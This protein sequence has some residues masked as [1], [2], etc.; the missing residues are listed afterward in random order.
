MEIIDPNI[1][2]RRIYCIH[3]FKREHRFLGFPCARQIVYE[4]TKKL[5]FTNWI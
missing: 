4:D 3:K 1:R 5:G 2:A